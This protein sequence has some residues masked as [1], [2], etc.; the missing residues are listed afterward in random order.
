VNLPDSSLSD[1]AARDAMM[2][3]WCGSFGSQPGSLQIK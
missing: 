1:P 2:Q 3:A